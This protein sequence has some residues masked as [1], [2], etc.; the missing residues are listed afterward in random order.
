[1][2]E[3]I[4]DLERVYCPEKKVHQKQISVD[5]M[6]FVAKECLQDYAGNYPKSPGFWADL[7]VSP[8]TGEKRVSLGG[9]WGHYIE[10]KPTLEFWFRGK[11]AIE[12]EGLLRTF[13]TRN[14]RD[15]WDAL[16]KY[17]L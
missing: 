15:S 12:L 13:A 9:D 7:W 1:M 17:L 8:E 3:I 4:E 5:G 16:E 6:R 11:E 10:G 14:D 2:S